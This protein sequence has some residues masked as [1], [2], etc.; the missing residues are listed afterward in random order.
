M[1]L[2]ETSPEERRGATQSAFDAP[3]FR[4]H[5]MGR[6]TNCEVRARVAIVDGQNDRRDPDLR[7]GWISHVVAQQ[8]AKLFQNETLQ[9][10]VPVAGTLAVVSFSSHDKRL[11][12]AKAPRKQEHHAP[13]LRRQRDRD[14][15]VRGRGARLAL[16]R[17]ERRGL[18]ERFEQSCSWSTSCREK[19]QR[20]QCD[21]AA[22]RCQEAVPPSLVLLQSHATG[23]WRLWVVRF[24]QFCA[25]AGHGAGQSI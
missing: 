10:S 15:A 7:Q 2:G 23:L 20:A 14:P 13:L 16:R 21:F 19:T 8:C 4:L 12:T 3:A 22:L 5:F 9:P 18:S 24:I 6:A 17:E 1:R 11:R 25:G